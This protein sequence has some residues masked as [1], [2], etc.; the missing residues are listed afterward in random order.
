MTATPQ[1]Q[2]WIEKAKETDIDRIVRTRNIKLGGRPP[3]LAGPCPQCGGTDRFSVHLGKQVFN[4]R[5]CGAKGHGAIDLVM[6]LDGSDFKGAVETLAGQAAAPKRVVQPKARPVTVHFPYRDE[7]GIPLSREVRLQYA[8]GRKKTWQEAADPDRPGE[9]IAGEGCM[10]G[11]RRVPFE[12]A[13][14]NEGLRKGETIFIVEGPRK[15]GPLREWG[16]CATC[17]MGGSGA[18]SIWQEHAKEFFL[19]VYSSPVVIL[20]DNDAP[21]TKSA[22]IIADALASVGVAVSM[23]DLPVGATGDIIDLIDGG[24]TREQFLD[25]VEAEARAWAPSERLK[26]N[27]EAFARNGAQSG[28]QKTFPLIAWKDIAFDLE[29]ECRVEG[30]LPLVGLACL[31]GGPGS[32]K[33][34][35]LLDLFARMARGGFWGGREVKQCPVVYI[36]A[37]GS[38]GIKKRIVGLKNVAAEKGLPADIPFHLI[39]VAP[40]PRQRQR[41]LQEAY[42][43]H[44]R[45]RSPA[46]ARSLS[47]RRRKHSLALTKTAPGWTRL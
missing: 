8:D 33:T 5:G 35:I 15:C 29:E 46:G 13:K 7:A 19:P 42:R 45:N 11:E 1:F 21:G 24:G 3:E 27:S 47:T 44:R 37:E 36:A 40:N 32:G 17:N 18:A 22:T 26:V 38:G 41:R 31:Y 9:W 16:L 12:L 39:T 23:L 14:L 10:T 25:L 28:E 6:F 2:A 43:G 34:F 4:C 20:P 30:V